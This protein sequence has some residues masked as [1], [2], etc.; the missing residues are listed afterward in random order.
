M[1]EVSEGTTPALAGEFGSR[2]L[3]PR[4][5]APISLLMLARELRSGWE[6]AEVHRSPSKSMFV[7]RRLAVAAQRRVRSPD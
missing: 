4:P 1:A 5:H 2:Y 7:R 6:I 3:V